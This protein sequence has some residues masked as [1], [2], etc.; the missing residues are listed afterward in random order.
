M[1]D[2]DITT[3]NKK[4]DKLLEYLK[5]LA[6]ETKKCEQK[7]IELEEE[8]N[9]VNNKVQELQQKVDL[10]YKGYKP[11]GITYKQF[12]DKE[13]FEMKQHTSWSKLSKQLNCS[14]G[15]LQIR[16]NRYKKEAGRL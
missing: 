4:I 9:R 6:T 14:I 16:V 2:Q 15:T 13:I 8:I 11:Q 5:G 3:L 7:D 12:S 1:N 10:L